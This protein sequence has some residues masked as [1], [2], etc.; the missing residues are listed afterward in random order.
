LS[1]EYHFTVDTVKVLQPKRYA[2]VVVIRIANKHE[3]SKAKPAILRPI[4]PKRPNKDDRIGWAYEAFFFEAQEENGTPFLAVF[5]H[6]REP[7]A[8]GGQWASESSL[9]PFKQL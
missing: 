1:R 6:W 3:L 7:H 9:P 2:P 8:G 5:N 4:D